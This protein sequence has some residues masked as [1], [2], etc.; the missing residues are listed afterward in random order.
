L[1]KRQEQ[2]SERTQEDHVASQSNPKHFRTFVVKSHTARM[3]CRAACRHVG[4]CGGIRRCS[5]CAEQGTPLTASPAFHADVRS[6]ISGSWLGVLQSELDVRGKVQI[7]VGRPHTGDAAWHATCSRTLW[8]A[9]VALVLFAQHPTLSQ[10]VAT[11]C[12]F[13][14]CK[15]FCGKLSRS[16]QHAAV[17][18]HA[19][20]V[21]HFTG[22]CIVTGF[23]GGSHMLHAI[24]CVV[25]AAQL[26]R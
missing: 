9:S 26:T 12:V 24:V 23:H 20:I 6:R 25:A 10:N 14:C 11:A 19:A 17:G 1:P 5:C 18:A 7:A 8:F 4:S 13:L 16:H 2:R 21:G 22:H 3:Q 15:D